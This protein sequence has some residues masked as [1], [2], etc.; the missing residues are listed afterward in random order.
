MHETRTADGDGAAEEGHADG[1]LVGDL[2]EGADQVGAFEVLGVKL[3][4]CGGK[5][6][7]EQEGMEGREE[8]R[9]GMKRTFDSWVH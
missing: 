8:E 4:Y 1:F 6:C 9:G 5:V 3:S 7:E 2:L